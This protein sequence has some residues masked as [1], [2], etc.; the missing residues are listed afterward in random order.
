[1]SVFPQQPRHYAQMEL[2]SLKAPER[3]LEKVFIDYVGPFR[4][5]K[6]GISYLI[7]G[8]PAPLSLIMTVVGDTILKCVY[9][10]GGLTIK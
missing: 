8:I 6:F 3:P 2:M 10:G 7:F 9:R 4:C 1:M 5:S